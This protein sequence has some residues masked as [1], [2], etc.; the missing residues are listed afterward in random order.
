[1]KKRYLKI[2][3]TIDNINEILLNFEKQIKSFSLKNDYLKFKNNK[4]EAN[5]DSSS[6]KYL[7]SEIKRNES[8]IKNKNDK[9]QNFLNNNKTYFDLKD[10]L[11]NEKSQIDSEQ[12]SSKN[13]VL[14]KDFYHNLKLNNETIGRDFKI[15]KI[16]D[17]S[18]NA[19]YI[20]NIDNEI[21]ISAEDDK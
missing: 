7:D 6:N 13:F 16:K 8:I 11:L 21:W 5:D 3:K 20:S 10:L 12:N 18:N 9:Y 14:N 4:N 19:D 15:K 2:N 17:N 1:M